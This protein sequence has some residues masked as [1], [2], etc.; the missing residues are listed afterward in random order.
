[1]CCLFQRALAALQ[2]L[3]SSHMLVCSLYSKSLSAGSFFFPAL[4]QKMKLEQA[5]LEMNWIGAARRMRFTVMMNVEICPIF[6]QFS[7]RIA[8]FQICNLFAQLCRLVLR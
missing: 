7:V 4:V 3:S 1:M 8:C 5:F 2:E 6:S